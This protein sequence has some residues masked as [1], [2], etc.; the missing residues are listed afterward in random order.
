MIVA[1]ERP[2]EFCLVRAHV[3]A[4]PVK[5]EY[6]LQSHAK[7]LYCISIVLSVKVLEGAF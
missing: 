1:I 6:T 3:A 7:S 4:R 5:L 2:T